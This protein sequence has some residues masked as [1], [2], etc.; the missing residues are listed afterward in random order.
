MGY[1]Q[2]DLLHLH[3]GEPATVLQQHKGR[4]RGREA[5]AV[6]AIAEGPVRWASISGQVRQQHVKHW[7]PQT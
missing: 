3:D 2:H 7:H 5:V 1:P 6:G 4:G